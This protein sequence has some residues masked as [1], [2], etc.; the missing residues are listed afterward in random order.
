MATTRPGISEGAVATTTTGHHRHRPKCVWG[1]GARFLVP[2]HM[3]FFAAM[4]LLTL[5]V[6]HGGCP[7]VIMEEGVRSGA[8]RV[9][10]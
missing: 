2:F 8:R 1:G 6:C 5:D 7:P 4:P 3:S 9:A 10:A